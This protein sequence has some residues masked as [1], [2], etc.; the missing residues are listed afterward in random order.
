MIWGSV[1][2]P[3]AAALICA[4]V[5]DHIPEAISRSRQLLGEGPYLRKPGL[6]EVGRHA[7]ALR[8]LRAGRIRTSFPSTTRLTVPGDESSPGTNRPRGR[9]VPGDESSPGTNRPRGRIIPG[10]EL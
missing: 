2:N 6:R 4:T 5:T 3:M 7:S 9:I 8:A 1:L 10:D